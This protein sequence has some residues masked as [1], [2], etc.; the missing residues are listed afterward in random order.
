MVHRI[1]SIHDL[2]AFDSGNLLASQYQSDAQKSLLQSQEIGDQH[3]KNVKCQGFTMFDTSFMSRYVW[4]LM[5][6]LMTHSLFTLLT[7][8]NNF[9]ILHILWRF[10]QSGPISHSRGRGRPRPCR[11]GHGMP[12]PPGEAGLPASRIP[13]DPSDPNIF[14]G[15]GM[16]DIAGLW[17]EKTRS[18]RSNQWS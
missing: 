5:I 8:W 17:R 6:R 7:F 1:Q 10:V 18:N 4:C 13:S 11:R 9:T 3:S 16:L 12:W 2:A 14:H 15:A